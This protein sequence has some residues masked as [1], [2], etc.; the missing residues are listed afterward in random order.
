MA[1]ETNEEI[2]ER[3]C[4]TVCGNCAM[5]GITILPDDV[6]DAKVDLVRQLTE[7]G[8]DNEQET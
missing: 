8:N 7:K 2:A 3:V 5:S 4:R 6:Q 1:H